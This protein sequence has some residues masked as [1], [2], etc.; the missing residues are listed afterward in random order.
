MEHWKE[1][2]EFPDYSVSTRGRVMNI[3]TERVLRLSQNQSGVVTVGLMKDGD[4]LHRSVALL[5]ATAF[6]PQPSGLFDT[7]ICLDGNRKNLHEYNLMWRP[8]WYAV[9]YNQQFKH[10]YEHSI[11][12]PVEN[13]G[14]KERHKN[15]WEASI[16]NGVLEKDLVLS[17][18]NNT[19]CWPLYQQFRVIPQ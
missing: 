11:T 13:L 16:F 15:S 7:P 14:T 1:I 5:V 8:R 17:I 19:F 4:Q 2:P 6:I 3:R 18:M 9:Q 10:P 12:H